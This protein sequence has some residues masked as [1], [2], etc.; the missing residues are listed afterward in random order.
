M[1]DERDVSLPR[2][3][4]VGMARIVDCVT[5]MDSRAMRFRCLWCPAKACS[6]SSPRQQT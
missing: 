2:G 4:I 6:G 5:T 1:D 3:G